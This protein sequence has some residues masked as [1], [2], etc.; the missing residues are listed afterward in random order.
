MLLVIEAVRDI[1]AIEAGPAFVEAYRAVKS[2][3]PNLRN[4]SVGIIQPTGGEEFSSIGLKY[5]VYAH[6]DGKRQARDGFFAI[7][8]VCGRSQG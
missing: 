3:K 7:E 1:R 2:T 8:A 6:P 5:I 4:M